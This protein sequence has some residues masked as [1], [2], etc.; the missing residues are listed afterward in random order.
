MGNK[1]FGFQ[2]RQIDRAVEKGIAPHPTGN[3]RLN[4]YYNHKWGERQNR[5]TEKKD[6]RESYSTPGSGDSS[7]SAAGQQKNRNAVF[8]NLSQ[9]GNLFGN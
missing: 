3:A 4:L 9:R 7:A 6:L 1:L 2:M 5:E 8:G